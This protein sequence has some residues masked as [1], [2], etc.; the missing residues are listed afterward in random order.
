MKRTFII[1]PK[2]GEILTLD[3][4]Y[5]QFKEG[6]LL[7]HDENPRDDKPAGFLSLEN[8]AAVVPQS[9]NY[10]SNLQ[11]DPITFRVYLKNRPVDEPLTVQ[12]DTCDS[13]KPPSLVFCV[14]GYNNNEIQDF[15]LR[16]VYVALAEVVAVVPGL[17]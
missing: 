11:L 9:R 2:E 15:P 4:E 16:D 10:R 1:Y 12:A 5:F 6:R 8:I 7:L 13:T 17:P 3:L 14:K